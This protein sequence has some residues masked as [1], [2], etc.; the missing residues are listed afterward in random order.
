MSRNSVLLPMEF[1]TAICNFLK[2]LCKAKAIFSIRSMHRFMMTAWKPSDCHWNENLQ[3]WI[4]WNE[5]IE[6]SEQNY[7]A[8]YRAEP[9]KQDQWSYCINMPDFHK[10]RL[11]LR[12]KNLVQRN[13]GIFLLL[14]RCRAIW[15]LLDETVDSLTRTLPLGK[16]NNKLPAI[17]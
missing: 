13:V 6:N 2:L 9:F 10:I 12:Y 4:S 7:K 11:Y 15:T 17:D 3:T 1:N 8:C 14:V 5:L 16:I